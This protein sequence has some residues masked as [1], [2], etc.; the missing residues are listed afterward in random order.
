M[1]LLGLLFFLMLIVAV[2]QARWGKPPD[3]MGFGTG[4]GYKEYSREETQ[5]LQQRAYEAAREMHIARRKSEEIRQE[6]EEA[7]KRVEEAQRE[8]AEARRKREER[9]KQRQRNRNEK[10]GLR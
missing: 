9:R 2:L 5:R 3:R 8:T 10:R 1:A 4:V 6:A 7:R